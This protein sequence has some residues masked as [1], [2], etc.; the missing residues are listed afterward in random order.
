MTKVTYGQKQRHLV[1]FVLFDIYD[2]N[3]NMKSRLTESA[4]E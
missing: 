1:G 2:D 3:S 4:A